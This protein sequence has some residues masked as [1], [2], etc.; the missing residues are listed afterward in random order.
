MRR[1][2]QLYTYVTEHRHNHVCNRVRYQICLAAYTSMHT[3]CLIKHPH[4]TQRS[5]LRSASECAVHTD[6]MALSAKVHA[7]L[8]ANATGNASDSVLPR[9][10]LLTAVISTAQCDGCRTMTLCCVMVT[11]IEATTSSACSRAYM[12]LTC[13]KKKAGCVQ[14]AMP[15]SGPLFSPLLSPLLSP[16]PSPLPSPLLLPPVPLAIKSL[17]S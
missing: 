4:Q 16:L 7:A 15:R 9:G 13:L 1:Y 11:A 8:A 2:K 12:L 17:D 10:T 3:F 14:H 5:C 6:N